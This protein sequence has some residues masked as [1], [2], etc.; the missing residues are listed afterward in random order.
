MIG[1]EQKP[2]MRVQVDRA[3]LHTRGLALEDVRTAIAVATSNAPEGGKRC[4][5]RNETAIPAP[6]ASNLEGLIE[7]F[8]A[9][10]WRKTLA[11]NCAL[12]SDSASTSVFAVDALMCPTTAYD[13]RSR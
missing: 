3:K 6:Y 5:S 8:S 13:L 10:L 9:E 4:K 11:R 2:A 7:G 1:G 12:N